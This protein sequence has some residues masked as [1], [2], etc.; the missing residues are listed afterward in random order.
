[1]FLIPSDYNRVIHLDYWWH[2]HEFC[3]ADLDFSF[4]LLRL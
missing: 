3:R 4:S 1:M 2:R